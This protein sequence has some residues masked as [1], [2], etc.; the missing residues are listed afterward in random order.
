[1]YV[2]HL[3]T[4]GLRCTA[5]L[6]FIMYK[7]SNS[8]LKIKGKSHPTNF[9]TLVHMG[10]H[11]FFSFLTVSVEV[12][13]AKNGKETQYVYVYIWVLWCPPETITTLFISYTQIQ[14]KIILNTSYVIGIM[15]MYRML[16]SNL[17]TRDIL[18]CLLLPKHYWLETLQYSF[19]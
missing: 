18:I 10:L 1:M 17:L 16:I 2:M 3:G 6:Y 15:V 9:I 11:T 14:N 5:M 13:Q 19:T 7:V 8:C 4:N 12:L